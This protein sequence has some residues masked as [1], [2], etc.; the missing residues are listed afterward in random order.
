M[1]Q[2]LGSQDCIESLRKDLVDL[3][4]AIL[5]VFSRTGPLR[6]SSWKFPDKHSCNLDMVALLEQYDFVDGEDAFNQHSHIVLLELV[7]DRL[8]L[9]VQ[10][11]SAYIDRL[12][13][14]HRRE[15]TPQK[16]CLSVGL[17]VTNYW[18]NLVQFANIKNLTS[19]SPTHSSPC[20]PVFS[21]QNK[22]CQTVES[23]L[24]PCDACHQVQT[25]L[26]KTGDAL[27]DLLQSEGLP[28][29]LQPLLAA[30]DDSLELGRM[31]A[32]DVSQWANEQRRDT[33]R[34]EKHL[35][36]VRC[37]VQP[38]K[39]RLAAAEEEQKRF[40]SQLERAQKDFNQ[41]KEKLQINSVQLEFSLQKAQRVI[42]ETEKRLHEEQ[43][44][45]K[46]DTMS[47]EEMNFKLKEEI[48]LQQNTLKALEH[49]K[50]GLQESLNTLQIEEEACSKL[51]HRIQ[52]LES[53]ISDIQLLLDKEKAKY[54]SACRQQESMQ[55]KQKSLLERVDALDEECEELQKQLG[56]RDERQ[57]GL[58]SQLQQMSEEKEELRAQ[59]TQQQDLCSKLQNEKQTL[60]T[61]TDELNNCVDELKEYVQA[62]RERERLL[63]AFPELSPLAQP[64]STGNVLLDMQQQ[65]QA[66]SIRIKV[67]E[68]EN[69]T[70]LR[71]LEKLGERAQHN[72]SREASTQ[73]THTVS[74][75]S[76][77]T[78]KRPAQSSDAAR[79]GYV[80]RGKEA[81]GG[82]SGVESE[83][84]VSTSPSSI[85][86]HLQTLHL[87]TA[88]TAAK[89][90]AKV[91]S[92]SQLYHSRAWNQ[93]KK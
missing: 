52:Q 50:K 2:L 83:D 89:S 33:R 78:E 15:Q 5:D 12:R 37:T 6:F 62:L 58:Q 72:A 3:Q 42:K 75:P 81:G 91:H 35:Q 57:I 18:S 17:I 19:T 82:E 39:D 46:R 48:A 54:Q 41:E 71:S 79:L 51:Q 87:N 23:S 21:S 59:L 7:V 70:L 34:L 30:V 61:H 25:L 88:C 49:E 66:N 80:N 68:Q 28:S 10:S 16:G 11:S 53:Q 13:G 20:S 1:S 55:A 14:S 40:R 60:Q 76:T 67:L 92:P 90:P 44:Q 93:R 63:V 8:L 22:S 26:R 4:G 29:S 77:P 73:Q 38:L 24:I 32:G 65:L 86:I 43:Q 84:R 56:E 31:T 47:L 9:L 69:S 85:Q 27:V 36:D 45:H 64:Q 74:L